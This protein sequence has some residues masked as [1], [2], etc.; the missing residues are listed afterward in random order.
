M[1][2]RLLRDY[3]NLH[4]IPEESFKEYKTHKYIL[5]KLR[6]LNCKIYEI[7]PTGLLVFF[8]YEKIDTIAF[9][10]EMDGLLIKEEND[11]EYKSIHQGLMHACGHDGHMA[12]LLSLAYILS[13]IKCPRN[14]C[15]IFQPSEESYGGAFKII[16]SEEYK[17]LNI[18]EVYGLHLWPNLKDGT[19]AS[20]ENELMAS[21]TEIDIKIKGKT[22]HIADKGD[23]VD[24]IKT[25]YKLLNEIDTEED[26]IFNCGKITSSGARNIVCEEVLLECSLRSFHENKRKEFLNNLDSIAKKIQDQTKTNIDINSKKHILE[27]KNNSHLFEKYRHLIDEI[28]LP[29]YKAEDF[30]FYGINSKC[31]FFFLGVGDT[32]GLHSNKFLFNPFVLEKGLELFLA[33]AKSY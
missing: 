11:I 16:S 28:I 8:D 6:L 19:I 27:V 18:K 4:Q 13:E 29:V 14:I 22:A 30:S 32:N 2:I 25:A 3:K 24:A 12:I 17:R 20:K 26:V 1:N 31:L 7:K 15:L 23:G 21:A 10:C 33:I 5:E 9:R